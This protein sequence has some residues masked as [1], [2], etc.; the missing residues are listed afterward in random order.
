MRRTLPLLLVATLVGSACIGVGGPSDEDQPD[1]ARHVVFDTDLAFDDIMAML[2]LLQRDDVVIDAVTVTG[3]GEA[4]C[5][6]GVANA[7]GLPALGGSPD[8]PVA[9]GRETPLK[10]SNAFPEEWRTAVDDLSML[11]LPQVDATPDPRGATGLL[12]ATLDGDADLIT[13][14]VGWSSIKSPGATLAAIIG[15]PFALFLYV[16]A[17]GWMVQRAPSSGYALMVLG[18]GALAL[19]VWPREAWAADTSSSP[20]ARTLEL[21][22]HSAGSL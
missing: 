3:T 17:V 15:L 13:L 4:H 7:K 12:L 14:A 18:A 11:D 20:R 22:E 21:Q 2:Y 6:P 19:A 10:G 16:P 8:T 5:A 9:C 1:G